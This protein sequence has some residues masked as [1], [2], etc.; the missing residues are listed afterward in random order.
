MQLEEMETFE[1]IDVYICANGEPISWHLAAQMVPHF[2]QDTFAL[3]VKPAPSILSWNYPQ[4]SFFFIGHTELHIVCPVPFS[5][6]TV[7]F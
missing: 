3:F 2:L 6:A 7:H 5:T 4:N 1:Y